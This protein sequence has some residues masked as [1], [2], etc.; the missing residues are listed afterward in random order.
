MRE[1]VAKCPRFDEKMPYVAGATSLNV[2]NVDAGGCTQLLLRYV[3]TGAPNEPLLLALL[4]LDRDQTLLPVQL[5]AALDAVVAS[6]WSG[7]MR[8]LERVI[9]RAVALP[10]SDFLEPDDLPSALLCGYADV[11]IP[12]LGC[13]KTMGAWGRRY[14]RVVLERCENNKH[15]ACRELAIFY[16]S[17]TRIR[18]TA[19]LRFY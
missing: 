7:N 4:L 2:A 12:S 13:K 18:H 9:E 10:G 3:S 5:S 17:W 16:D 19:A 14:A 6:D 11:P 15:R 1:L 8:E